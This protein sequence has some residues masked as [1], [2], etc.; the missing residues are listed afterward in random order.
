MKYILI[1]IALA[2]SVAGCT[3]EATLETKQATVSGCE[4]FRVDLQG[5]DK[6][7]PLYLAKCKDTATVTYNTGGK[8]NYTGVTVTVVEKE[9][10]DL[11]EKKAELDKKKNALAKL[12]DE[13]K[14]L[15]GLK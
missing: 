11:E 5:Q 2:L 1:V 9:Q 14:K 15:L 3:N 12:S 10:A 8:S 4:I 7:R 6:S 13:E